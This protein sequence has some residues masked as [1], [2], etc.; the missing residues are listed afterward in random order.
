MDEI[1]NKTI[2]HEGGWSNHPDD[3][4]GQTKFGITLATY[5]ALCGSGKTEDDLRKLTAEQAR[6]L[7][8]THYWDKTPMPQL[9]AKLRAVMFDMGVN[10][11]PK[12][13]YR[14]LQYAIRAKGGDI[15]ADGV[16]GP[17]SI[18]AASMVTVNDLILQRVK[19]YHDI[20]ENKSSQRVFL[21]GWIKRALSYM[22]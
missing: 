15:V 4:G 8:R 6:A 3:K 1:I 18:A 2:L 9:P 22:E 21:F 11:G 16:L 19:F 13:A 10:H 12:N 7:Y 14:I 5:K 20:V 17:K